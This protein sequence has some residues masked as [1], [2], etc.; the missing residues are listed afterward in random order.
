[1]QAIDESG[2]AGQRAGLGHQHA[3]G[4]EQQALVAFEQFVGSDPARGSHGDV[5]RWEPRA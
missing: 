1:M 2:R 5:C 4:V 3:V